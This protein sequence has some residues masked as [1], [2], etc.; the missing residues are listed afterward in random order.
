MNQERTL[1]DADNAQLEIDLVE[2]FHALL[3]RIYIIILAGILAAFAAFAW[4]QLFVTP[5]YTSTTSMYMMAKSSNDAAIT[6]TD[7]QMATQLTP[8]YMEI[9]KSRTVL[10]KVI[11]TLNLDMTA[12]ELSSCITTSNT[13]NTRIMTITVEHEDPELAQDIANTLREAA[14]DEIVDIMGIEA[15]NT[16]EEAN[17]PTGP[18]S[19]SVMKKTVFG[20]ALGILLSAGVLILIYLLDDTIKTPDDVERYLGLSLLTSIPLQAG[21][22]KAKKIRKRAAKRTDRRTKH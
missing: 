8:D 17:L 21:E 22:K 14:G 15:V 4:T 16:I 10:E 5:K 13:S 6:S 2:L 11:A 7:L 1:R 19:P 20:G 9:A 3:N 18:S 12:G